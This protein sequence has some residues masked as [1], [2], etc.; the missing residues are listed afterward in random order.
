[1]VRWFVGSGTTRAQE[2]AF[3]NNPDDMHTPDA[4]PPEDEIQDILDR[5]RTIAVVGLSDNPRKA[6]YE[7]AEYLKKHGYRIIP[8]NPCLEN[9]L[10][11]K[12]YPDLKAVP[13][14]V[15]VVDV[16]R[17]PEAVPGVVDDAIG[18]GAK[19]VWLQL[20]IVNNQAAR[21]ARGAGLKVVQSRCMMREIERGDDWG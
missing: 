14:D 13:I 12:C 18:I 10:G 7:V 21:K 11:E 4:N 2:G 15:D 17:K 3:M 6:S 1:M 16:F 5:Y 19:V 8:V 9:V 20:G